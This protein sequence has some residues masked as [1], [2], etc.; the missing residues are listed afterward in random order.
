[1]N[2]KFLTEDEFW[3]QY[4]KE[5][6]AAIFVFDRM[7][8][9]GFSNNALA[10]FDFNFIS[11]EK[12]KLTS[13]GGF[14]TENY[15]YKL[16]SPQKK[17]QYWIIEGRSTE[18]PCTV[19]NL[20][21]WAI[22]LNCKGFEFDCKLNG[23]SLFTNIQNPKFLPVENSTADNFYNKGI[24]AISTR[25]YGGAIICFTTAIGIDPRHAESWQAR[26]YCKEEIFASA[27]ART[28]YEKAL[29]VAPGNIAALLSL[30]TNK[31]DAGE[32][33]AAL[34]DYNSLLQLDPDN[35]MAYFNRGN[36]KFSLGNSNGACEDW[37]KARSLGS[38]YAQERLD[39][40]CLAH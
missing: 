14:L 3:Q 10:S 26:G 15:E 12:E 17:E 5:L 6:N 32:H 33:E 1:M 36:T 23:Y 25:N 13:L 21:F 16:R 24:D 30:A 18:Q 2:T 37:K 7:T 38:P 27:A 34:H 40:E 22:D 35:S 29:T 31:D 19:H 4:H 39:E 9:D 20:I 28:D 11:N 8:A